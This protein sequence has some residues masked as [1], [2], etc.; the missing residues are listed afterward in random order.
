MS[1]GR[2]AFLAP[3]NVYSNYEV[4]AFD[5]IVIVTTGSTDKTITL[6][7]ANSSQGKLLVVTKSDSGAGKVI[8]AARD[9]DTIDGGSSI[10]LTVQD[11]LCYILSFGNNKWFSN[12]LQTTQPYFSGDIQVGSVTAGNVITDTI[13]TSGDLS[14]NSTGKVNVSTIDVGATNLSYTTITSSATAGSYTTYFINCSSGSVV[15]T[16]PSAV[17]YPKRIYNIVRTVNSTYNCIIA[18]QSGQT[19]N[20]E[21]S[22]SLD[23]AGQ[24]V[25]V[26]SEGANWKIIGRY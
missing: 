11:A 17:T 23:M 18:P 1:S 16:L 19:I 7:R 4:T 3:V 12:V 13:T 21:N 8:I 5:S 9:G 10:Q 20:G 26:Q 15:L 24:C 14:I 6:P 2:F 22:W 25:V